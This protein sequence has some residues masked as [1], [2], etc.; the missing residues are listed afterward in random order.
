M[1]VKPANYLTAIIAVLALTVSVGTFALGYL[2]SERSEELQR[3]PILVFQ[4]D[5]AQGWS[6][7][8]V[9]NGPAVN[10]VI[11]GSELGSTWSDPVRTPPIA[12]G[13][14]IQ[15]RWLTSPNLD[16]L[17]AVYSGITGSSYNTACDDDLN[18]FDQVNGMSN[19]PA[20]GARPMWEAL[21]QLVQATEP[22]GPTPLPDM[23]RGE[24]SP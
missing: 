24:A 4:Y 8:N 10:V 3:R 12:S 14:E 13:G 7:K 18:S 16:K 6:V 2:Q 11:V 17:G 5:G 1:D 21:A 23:S 20:G 15:L 19:W 9:G 22:T